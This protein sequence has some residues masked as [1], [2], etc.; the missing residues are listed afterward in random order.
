MGQGGVR[1]DAI[2]VLSQVTDRRK[3][4]G[5]RDEAGVVLTILLLTKMSGEGGMSGM[6]QWARLRKAWLQS[7][8][9]LGRES[10]PCGNTYQY[11]CDHIDLD[12]MNERLA[13]LFRPTPRAATGR[14]S[15]RGGGVGASHGP[16]LRHWLLDGKT[17]CGSQRPA[18][19]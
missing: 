18:H 5:K 1:T 13:D 15:T 10:L 16:G 4:K 2:Q 3:A 8:L 6:V 12:E 19:G 14:D 17:L 11:V 9:P 7:H